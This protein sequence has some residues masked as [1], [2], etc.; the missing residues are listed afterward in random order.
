MLAAFNAFQMVCLFAALPFIVNWLHQ[1][2]FS[3]SLPLMWLAI[4]VYVVMFIGNVIVVGE[5]IQTEK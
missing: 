5:K 1:A 2:E 3:G 4:V